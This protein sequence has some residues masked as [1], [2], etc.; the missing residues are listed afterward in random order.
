MVLVVGKFYKVYTTVAKQ[1]Q[2]NNIYIIYD[3]TGMSQA[4]HTITTSSKILIMFDGNFSAH[5]TGDNGQKDFKLVRGSTRYLHWRCLYN[6]TR[7][8]TNFRL[9]DAA[10]YI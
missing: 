1:I 8:S 4:Y 2:L 6:R 10:T 3:L 9:I 5:S 7:T